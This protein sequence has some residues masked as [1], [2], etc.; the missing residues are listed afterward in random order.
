[1][2]H[3]STAVKTQTQSQS[4]SEE[5]ERPLH[6]SEGRGDGGVLST[7]ASP[8]FCKVTAEYWTKLQQSESS[9]RILQ[10]NTQASPVFC[11]NFVTLSLLR[12]EGLPAGACC[13]AVRGMIVW[14]VA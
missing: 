3:H 9:L 12:F 10:Q 5:L 4:C 7:Q 2:S 13:S 8:V 1:M 14:A 6:G 11:F